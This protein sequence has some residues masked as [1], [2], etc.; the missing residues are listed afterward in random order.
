MKNKLWMGREIEGQYKGELTLFISGNDIAYHEIDVVL[1]SQ[2][3]ITQLYFGAGGCTA[4]DNDL[5]K[6][7]IKE[8]PELRITIELFPIDLQ[9]FEE[10]FNIVHF[11]FTVNIHQLARLKHR[12]DE[13]QIKLQSLYRDG[14]KVLMITTLKNFDNVN[15]D[16]LLSD[17]T[18]EGDV[19]LK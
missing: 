8:Y 3:H 17:K 13:H 16:L 1:Q 15:A 14:E 7:C 10:F 2:V 6:M 5:L 18:Y 11:M 12:R 9:L 19:V 4:V